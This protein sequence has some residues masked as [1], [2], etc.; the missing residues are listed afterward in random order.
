[1]AIP[2]G[3]LNVS[4]T[5]MQATY[6]VGLDALGVLLFAGTC[7]GL[8]STFF[9]GRMIGHFGMERYLMAGG[10][11]MS[12]GLLGYA[13]AGSWLA[14]IAAAFLMMIGFSIFNVG[15]NM[16]V[17][18]RYTLGQLNWMHAAYGL[19]G[20]VGPALT[21]V[22]VA[23]LGQ[24]WHVAYL[25]VFVV[26][27]LVTIL[28][29]ATR[30]QW[31]LAE[32]VKLGREGDRASVVESLR[33]PIVLLGMLTFF[34]FSG[35]LTGT[36]QLSAP[37]LTA[38]GVSVAQAGFWISCYWASFTAGRIIMGFVAHRI[39]STRLTRM[40]L[41]GSVGGAFLLLQNA[42]TALNLVGLIVIGF[43][44][45]PMFATLIGETRKNIPLRYR[46]NAIGFQ[47]AASGLGQALI[48]GAMAWYAEH[49]DINSIPAF[50]MIGLLAALA[51][52]EITMR[53]QAQTAAAAA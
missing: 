33:I 38:R 6:G 52:T 16:Y 50:P 27:S 24:S 19:G 51:L 53:R 47:L 45:S 7:G 39:D 17:S 32:E 44:C 20:T 18:A 1:M 11:S 37:L 40:C 21:T 4:W 5:L 25:I 10:V 26:M 41:I 35:V 43:A 23:N 22:L 29:I 30:S 8:I 3:I 31:I 9:S 13:L 12:I 46:A 28:L 49:I 42:S 34:I 15:L 36:S 2:T 48:P 14:L